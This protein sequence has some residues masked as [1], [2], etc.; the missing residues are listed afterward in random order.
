MNAVKVSA[1]LALLS[2]CVVPSACL[3]D[4]ANCASAATPV[5][6]AICAYQDLSEQR[7]DIANDLRYLLPLVDHQA[8]RDA[9]DA[10]QR[11]WAATLAAAC[12]AAQP[13]E[14]CLR[15]RLAARDNEIY[16]KLDQARLFG[17]GHPLRLGPATV[18]VESTDRWLDG[19][20][21]TL[22]SDGR[23]ISSPFF[24]YTEVVRRL[25]RPDLK[26]ALIIEGEGGT[27]HCGDYAVLSF[28]PSKGVRHTLLTTDSP[29]ADDDAPFELTGET[30]DGLYI[31]QEPAPFEQRVKIVWSASG[32]VATV[33]LAFRPLPG[34]RLREA[35][36]DS[37]P[38][39]SADLFAAIERETGPDTSRF[40]R[41]LWHLNAYGEPGQREPPPDEHAA[42]RI[43]HYGSRREGDLVVLR[44]CGWDQD[45]TGLWCGDPD[46]LAIAD[47]GGH[48]FFAIRSVGKTPAAPRVFPSLDAWPKAARSVFQSWRAS[49]S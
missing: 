36:A 28:Q 23:V 10:G 32:T 9:I 35:K 43:D 15:P 16:E 30:P 6:R 3:A 13:I 19:A 11:R 12:V 41:A 29:C 37:E 4:A 49:P 21:G 26:A 31:S 2:L 17:P 20:K 38:L 22:L 1:I 47:A 39:E 34:T 46:A 40:Q 44:G 24:G 48:F 18:E 45:H 27:E 25:D 33:P 8:E 42:A 5:D 14:A 7:K